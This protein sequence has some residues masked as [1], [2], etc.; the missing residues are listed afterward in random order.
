MPDLRSVHF[1]K[2]VDIDDQNLINGPKKAYEI[3]EE[4][5]KETVGT[6][7]YSNFESFKSSRTYRRKKRKSHL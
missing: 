3:A 6:N 4:K 5:F 7:Y 2:W 1:Q